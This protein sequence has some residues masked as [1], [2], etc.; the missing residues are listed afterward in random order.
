M[1]CFAPLLVLPPTN[2]DAVLHL[3][4]QISV[5][6]GD[7]TNKG[8]KVAYINAIEDFAFGGVITNKSGCGTT[9]I[10]HISVNL[11]TVILPIH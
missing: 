3:T 7:N 8:E 9:L 1:I 4:P 10:S 11:L 2:G 5:L 6:V